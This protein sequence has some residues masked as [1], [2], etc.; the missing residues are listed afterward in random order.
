MLQNLATPNA[1]GTQRRA[2]RLPRRSR[3]RR[4]ASR[5]CRADRSGRRPRAARWRRARSIACR[6]PRRSSRP[7]PCIF[8]ASNGRPRAARGLLGDDRHHLR[9]LLAAHHRDARV[10]PGEQEARPERA[11]AHAVMAGAERAADLQRELRHVG[12]GDGLDHLRAVLDDARGLR[13]RRRRDSRSC[14]AGRRS[15]GRPGSRAG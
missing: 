5:G 12:V 8:S 6:S 11:P 4:R 13:R 9:R 14:S 2:R 3:G 10:R 15:A 7:A 1:V